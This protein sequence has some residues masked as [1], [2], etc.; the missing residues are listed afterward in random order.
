MKAKYLIIIAIFF[1]G[2][3]FANAQLG[4]RPNIIFDTDMG[5]DYDDVGAIA[6]LHA[7]ADSNKANILATIASTKYEGVGEVLDVLNRYFGRPTVPIGVPKGEAVSKKDHQG[8]SDTIRKKY[9]H[10]GRS[11]EDFEDA[12]KLYRRL[13]AQQPDSSV[14]IVTVG[15]MTN[16]AD[17]L[18]SLPDEQ[19]ALT[20]SDLVRKKVKLLVSMAGRFPSGR[21]FNIH[22]DAPSAKTVFD[23]WPTPVILSGFEIGMKVKTGLPL[24]NNKTIVNS[25][26]KDVFRISIPMS[27]QDSLGRMS[28]D[29]TAVM[30][31]INGTQPFYYLE[32]GTMSIATDGS[33]TWDTTG[34]K[35]ARLVEQLPTTEVE[36]YINKLMQH[37]PVQGRNTETR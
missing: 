20:G 14:T 4:T 16:L 18:S 28:W 30:V 11:N 10:A 21:E 31:A 27:A 17:L 2:H 6:V 7:L 9:P 8:W 23:N 34:N 19:T 1:V 33:N 24:I 13:L 35:H 37:Q 29:Q 26:V 5:P 12:V 22:E 36:A 25:P 15:F 32:Y 3:H